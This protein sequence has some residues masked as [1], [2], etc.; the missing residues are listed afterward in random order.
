MDVELLGQERLTPEV[1][2][3]EPVERRVA[4]Y[5]D[6][7]VPPEC[8][9][10]QLQVSQAFLQRVDRVQLLVDP[11]HEQFVQVVSGEHVVHVLLTEQ[12]HLVLGP[13]PVDAFLHEALAQIGGE[14]DQL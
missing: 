10:Q 4:L 14:P 12:L 8:V 2:A 13:S 6:Q 9:L 3:L 11:E 7:V 5:Q 1:E